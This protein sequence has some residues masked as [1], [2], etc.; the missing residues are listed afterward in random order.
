M[1]HGMVLLHFVAKNSFFVQDKI[2]ALLICAVIE[3]LQLYTSY[4]K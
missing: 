3:N 4:N 2:K 1:V